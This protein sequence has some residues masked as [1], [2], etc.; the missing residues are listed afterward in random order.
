MWLLLILILI[1]C[2]LEINNKEK[3][4]DININFL[5]KEDSMRFIL[6]DNDNY[7]KNFTKYDLIA[8]KSNSIKD[9]YSKI[10]TIDFTNNQ[11]ILISKLTSKIDLLLPNKIASI[12]WNLALTYDSTYES[13]SPHTREDVIFLSTLV[14]FENI[15]HLI[16]TLLHE[17]IHI[18]QRL[19]PED[20]TILLNKRGYY[21]YK[22]RLDFLN[23]VPLLRSNPDLDNYIY[24]DP[25]GLP[26]YSVYNNN[27]PQSVQ[28]I[29]T[30][31]INSVLYEHP[32]E[33]MAYSFENWK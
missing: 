28:D 30:V 23:E 15:K 26:M 3:F 14:D 10:I 24:I 12:K 29:K 7:F 2:L 18:Y 20:L 6:N 5:S 4:T 17:K 1:V 25:D 27:N 22:K 8:R 21:K 31:P 11:K 19:Y 13:G 32:F 33:L 9:Y 16:N